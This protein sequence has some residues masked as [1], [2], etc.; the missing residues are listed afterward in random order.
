MKLIIM[1]L[2]SFPL[3]LSVS[4]RFKYSQSHL[5]LKRPHYFHFTKWVGSSDNALDMLSVGARFESLTKHRL[6]GDFHGIL[7]FTQKTVVTVL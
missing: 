7:H 2:C 6:C 3:L 5:V 1:K 4:Q